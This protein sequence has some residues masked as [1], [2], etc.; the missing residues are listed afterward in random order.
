MY[1]NPVLPKINTS[2]NSGLRR[3]NSQDIC[4]AQVQS[5]A[6]SLN[7]V[8]ITFAGTQKNKNLDTEKETKKLLKQ[9]DD[10]LISSMDPEESRQI[11]ED[12][13]NA[14]IWAVFKKYEALKSA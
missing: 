3:Q 10:I 14:R 8:Q 11:Y 13:K 7:K 2:I 12:Q 4:S 5:P 1:I 6:Q 9:F